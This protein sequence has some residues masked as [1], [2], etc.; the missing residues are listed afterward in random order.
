MKDVA[1][2]GGKQGSQSHDAVKGEVS[3]WIMKRTQHPGDSEL[4]H[5]SCIAY[6]TP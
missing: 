4:W 2:A 3:A 1:T 6:A 5:L